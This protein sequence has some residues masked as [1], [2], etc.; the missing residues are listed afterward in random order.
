MSAPIQYVYFYNPATI[1][2]LEAQVAALQTDVGY[3]QELSTNCASYLTTGAYTLQNRAPIYGGTGGLVPS[4]FQNVIVAD[5]PST[6][7]LLAPTAY[8]GQGGHPGY[9]VVGGNYRTGEE[10]FGAS[11]RP[12]NPESNTW[13]YTGTLY[14]FGSATKSMIGVA[15]TKM[16]EEGLIK[17]TDK[18]SKYYSAMSGTALFYESVTV[19]S[20]AAFPFARDSYS[21]TTGTFDL[22]AIT[23]KTLINYNFGILN[24]FFILPN[25]VFPL[26]QSLGINTVITNSNTGANPVGLAQYLQFETYLRNLL[27]GNPIGPGARVYDGDLAYPTTQSYVDVL[28][29]TRN[30]TVPFSYKPGTWVNDSL[31]FNI[32]AQQ[33]T[34]DAGFAFLCV[35]IDSY[36]KSSFN[37]TSYTCLGDYMRAK[38]FTPLGM[39][40]TY[41]LYQDTITNLGKYQLA[42]V[43]F[44]RSAGF[45]GANYLFAPTLTGAG[46]NAFTGTNNSFQGLESTYAGLVYAGAGFGPLS[47]EQLRAQYGFVANSYGCSLSYSTGSVSQLKT[48]QATQQALIPFYWANPNIGTG[49]G[50]GAA[51]AVV[52]AWSAGPLAWSRQ[53]PDD[54]L[55][56]CA[57]GIFYYTGAG[58]GTNT[59][60]GSSPVL[61]TVSDFMKYIKMIANRGVG[62]NG[63]R[64]L[65]TE[66]WSYLTGVKIPGLSLQGGDGTIEGEIYG[67]TSLDSFEFPNLG[68]CFGFFR[69]NRDITDQTLYGLDDNSLI[70]SGVT[71][72]QWYV[73]LF[74]GNY[75]FYASTEIGLSSGANVLAGGSEIQDRK[76]MSDIIVQIIKD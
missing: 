66:S 49:A 51:A 18:C 38:I 30:G 13:N 20:G 58:T 31:P 5:T 76:L 2:A 59:P 74:T 62:A 8:N 4:N 46:Y 35:V 9:C 26:S 10:Y 17:A 41:T 14:N 48:Q 64:I 73:D 22:G 19:N 52:A 65:K 7:A 25:A 27:L 71:G 28:E 3:G 29:S 12:V 39:N 6:L 47:A 34:Y 60:L 53:Y 40:D 70:M 21:G 63:A 16:F 32:R 72:N 56:R 67:N 1:T 43:A 44:R 54:G 11:N 55:S 50:T 45:G 68:F 37:T 24:D 42:D 57:K 23:I 36:F 33:S 75:G 69:G 15:C 61:S